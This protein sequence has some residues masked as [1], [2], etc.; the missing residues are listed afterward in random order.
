MSLFHSI[1]SC[2]YILEGF[3]FSIFVAVKIT[4]FF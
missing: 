4:E 1:F 2:V 3:E